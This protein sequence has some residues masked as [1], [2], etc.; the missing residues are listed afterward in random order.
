[1]IY[2]STI[3]HLDLRLFVRDMDEWVSSIMAHILI[4]YRKEK[5]VEGDFFDDGDISTTFWQVPPSV[6]GINRLPVGIR[7]LPY[8]DSKI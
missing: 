6:N 2:S 7:A 8:L 3:A 5:N 1:M 4:K